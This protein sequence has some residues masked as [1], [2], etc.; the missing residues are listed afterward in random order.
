MNEEA[1]SVTFNVFLK[2]EDGL[3]VAHCLEL[4]IVATAKNEKEA[5]RDVADLI[6]AQVDYAFRNDNLDHLYRPAPKEVWK[7]F[8]EC[9]GRREK[10]HKLPIKK[11][12]SHGKTDFV[13]PR[14]TTSTC[15]MFEAHA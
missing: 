4:D 2:K 9:K 5:V 8:Y 3:F 1:N 14:I 6:M 13:P 15:S 7:E 10:I 11:E 12:S